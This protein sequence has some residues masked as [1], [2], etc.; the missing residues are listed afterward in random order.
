MQALIL[1][2]AISLS[3]FAQESAFDETQPLSAEDEHQ[4]DNYIHQG[5]ADKKYLE[6]C[7]GN[8]GCTS[9]DAFTGGA[10]A[11]VDK[12]MPMVSQM[13]AMFSGLSGGKMTAT[14][15]ENDKPVKVGANQQE[16]KPNKDGDYLDA[17][18]NKVPQEQ[19]DKSTD[20]TEKKTDICGYIPMV[21]EPAAALY[22]Q[23]QNDTTQQNYQ[24]SEP[25]ARQKASMYALSKVHD[26]RSKAAKYQFYGWGA[27]AGCYAA[28]LMSPTGV[29]DWQ[30]SA[31]LGAAT[32]LAYFYNKK[33]NA[34]KDRS[35][36]LKEM[37]E[38]LPG[39]GDC[40]PHTDT[41]CFCAEET[42]YGVDP[43]NYMKYCVAEVLQRTGEIPGVPCVTS[44]GEPD[45]KCD[46]KAKGTCINAKL[47]SGA[48]NLGLNPAQMKD[49]LSGL[50]HLSTGYE[51]GNLAPLA[52]K[53][54][55]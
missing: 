53:N 44:E 55:A 17:K 36:A 27:T 49:P 48:M 20:K 41:T 35:A 50:Q 3:L 28:Y 22:Q 10:W 42:S 33:E 26:D 43:T 1:T 5:V 32:F 38:K 6:M 16:F 14:V 39:A 54:L 13:Y 34:H 12:M 15:M 47:V 21:T 19:L 23:T 30:T 2:F 24:S 4:A 9:E 45:P 18:G 31:K 7:E 51:S 46:C 8:T 37:A 40:N 25:E 52:N 11:T 29:A